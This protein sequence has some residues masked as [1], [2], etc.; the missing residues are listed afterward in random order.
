MDKYKRTNK[1]VL[2]RGVKHLAAALGTLVLG[3]ITVYNSFMNKDHAL[4][5]PVLV[6]GVIFMLLA[7]FLIFRGIKLMLDSFFKQ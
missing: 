5:I 6:I 7:I 3:P 2:A 1:N 4:F